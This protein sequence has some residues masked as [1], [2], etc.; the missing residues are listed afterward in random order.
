M[1]GENVDRTGSTAQQ[2]ANCMDAFWEPICENHSWMEKEACIFSWIDKPER[3]VAGAFWRRKRNIF[4]SQV[5]SKI[6][7]PQS[8]KAHILEYIAMQTEAIDDEQL[9]VA[10]NDV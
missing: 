10:L 1:R 7:I 9:Q 3:T 6:R 8:A 5:E 2:Y 4:G